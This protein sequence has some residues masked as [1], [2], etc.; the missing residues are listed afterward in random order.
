MKNGYRIKIGTVPGGIVWL[1]NPPQIGEKF[2]LEEHPKPGKDHKVF[3][4]PKYT[5]GLISVRVTEVNGDIL[6]VEH[7]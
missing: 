7:W 5:S 2:W 1:A 3:R 4:R 6:F